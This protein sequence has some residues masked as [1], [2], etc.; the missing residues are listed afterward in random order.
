MPSNP[1]RT[2]RPRWQRVGSER[3][4]ATGA[5][6]RRSAAA[7]SAAAKAARAVGPLEQPTARQHLGGNDANGTQPQ[8]ERLCGKRP[9][10]DGPNNFPLEFSARLPRLPLGGMDTNASASATASGGAATQPRGAL[11]LVRWDVSPA[12]EAQPSPTGAAGAAG[13][14]GAAGAMDDA[15]GEAQLSPTGALDIDARATGAAGAMDD[16]PGEA[17]LSPTGA[18]DIDARVAEAAAAC[19][20]EARRR[21]RVKPPSLPAMAPIILCALVLGMMQLPAC[22]PVEQDAVKPVTVNE[23]VNP[24]FQRAI[25]RCHAAV[26]QAR[27][28]QEPC[29][30]ELSPPC[31]FQCPFNTSF[32]AELKARRRLLENSTTSRLPMLPHPPMIPPLPHGFCE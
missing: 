23:R 6:R 2:R 13:A 16:A 10:W 15:P 19:A 7:A 20:R 25:L 12:G 31:L 11:R 30:P 5:A 26:E 24:H 1:S 29:D 4:A 27:I 3:S 22:D 17:Q 18:L 8:E 32:Q 9:R 14:T 28:L 21:A